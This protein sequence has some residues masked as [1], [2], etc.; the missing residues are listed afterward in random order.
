MVYRLGFVYI[1]F[2]VL[3]IY[4]WYRNHFTAGISISAFVDC[5]RVTSGS[6]GAM[7]VAQYAPTEASCSWHFASTRC[8]TSPQCVCEPT[9]CA[10]ATWPC[11]AAPCRPSVSAADRTCP[12]IRSSPRRPS[13]WRNSHE[14][15]R[16]A[17]LSGASYDCGLNSLHTGC[18][19]ARWNLHLVCTSNAASNRIDNIVFF[20]Y[21]IWLLT[22]LCI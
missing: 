14:M 11:S 7:T 1:V 8:A 15:Y 21:S 22:V 13:T 3:C 2:P 4:L 9:T 6:A 5:C 19:S 10:V 20:I 16:S 18:S 17:V 12:S